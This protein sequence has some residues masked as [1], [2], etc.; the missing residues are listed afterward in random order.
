MEK[1]DLQK[2]A[3]MID[4]VIIRGCLNYQI[5]GITALDSAKANELCFLRNGFEAHHLSPD[6]RAVVT[7]QEFGPYLK[8]YNVQNII[9]VSDI[10]AAAK[11]LE[12]EFTRLNS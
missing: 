8:R 1:I 2:V 11:K 10:N 6:V 3:S 9:V 7:L 12:N 5:K 4:G